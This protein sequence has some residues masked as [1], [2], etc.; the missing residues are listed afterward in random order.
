MPHIRSHNKPTTF[1]IEIIFA[2]EIRFQNKI[3][4]TGDKILVIPGKGSQKFFRNFDF[5]H[6][7]LFDS[8]TFQRFDLTNFILD[9]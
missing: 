6:D 8:D 1:S 7:P 3:S 2:V 9:G 4:F 5:F